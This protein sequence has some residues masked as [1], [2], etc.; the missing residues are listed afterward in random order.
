MPDADTLWS[1]KL[2]D[3]PLCQPGPASGLEGRCGRAGV[4]VGMRGG[5]GDTGVPSSFPA[6]SQLCPVPLT[7][8]DSELTGRGSGGGKPVAGR[9]GLHVA[10]AHMRF[11]QVIPGVPAAGASPLPTPL[12]HPAPWCWGLAPCW[13]P[14]RAELC[15]EAADLVRET[16]APAICTCSPGP[17]RTACQAPV[18]GG[19]HFLSRPGAPHPAAT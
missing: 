19:V 9:L 10:L 1:P 11:P 2:G 17:L 15:P 7:P 3:P 4:A 16:R 8:A 5:S 18:T 6:P 14:F 13:S 12:T